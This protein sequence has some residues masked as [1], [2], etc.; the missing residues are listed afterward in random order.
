VDPYYQQSSDKK[1][2]SDYPFYQNGP[3]TGDFYNIKLSAIQPNIAYN[4][5]TE[6]GNCD[7][8]VSQDLRRT[9]STSNTDTWSLSETVK[10][11]NAATVKVGVPGFT[12]ELGFRVRITVRV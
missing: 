5:K 8:P 1:Y 12:G 11:E 3:V 7:Q 6:N 2:E 4:S 10:L 9:V